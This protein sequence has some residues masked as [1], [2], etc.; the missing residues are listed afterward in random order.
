MAY[1]AK[2]SDR[3]PEVIEFTK[4]LKTEGYE[5][6]AILGYCWGASMTHTLLYSAVRLFLQS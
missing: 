1:S 3:L 2:L 6:V 4:F 5:K